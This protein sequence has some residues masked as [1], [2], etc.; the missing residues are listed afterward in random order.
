MK[1]TSFDFFVSVIIPVFNGEKFLAEAIESV[2]EQNYEPLEII[3][4]DDGSTD[5]TREVADRFKKNIKYVYQKNKKVSSARN[6]GIALSK[7]D[8]IG[9]IDHDDRW[10]KGRL[11][12]H[13][14][15]LAKDPSLELVI[16]RVQRFYLLNEGDEPKNYKYEYLNESFLTP[17]VG[18]ATFRKSVFDKVGLFDEDI[19]MV[20]DIDWSMRARGQ[21]IRSIVLNQCSL[22]YLRHQG[23][24]TNNEE[25]LYRSLAGALKKSLNR[26]CN[27]SNIADTV[28]PQLDIE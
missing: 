17:S 27:Q 3:V 28:L 25:L 18:A 4:V 13:L 21:N 23:N 1:K 12:T 20:E 19:S 16:G 8:I 11:N 7:G 24:M 22:R 9:F 26:R 5:R 14:S 2:L 10:V 15:Y 6:K